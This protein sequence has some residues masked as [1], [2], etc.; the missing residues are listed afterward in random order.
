ME[1]LAGA[2]VAAALVVGT[3]GSAGSATAMGSLAIAL[4]D[5]AVFFGVTAFTFTS[6]AD[7]S[8]EEGAAFTGL[9]GAALGTL[10][11]AAAAFSAVLVDFAGAFVLAGS[12]GLAGAATGSAAATVGWAAGAPF[13]A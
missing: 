7:A 4:R 12:A 5:L 10:T 8:L 11:G 3:L 9:A 2:L 1:F 13:T 6:V